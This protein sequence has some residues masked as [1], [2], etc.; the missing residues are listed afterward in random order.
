[1]Q[2]DLACLPVKRAL[3]ALGMQAC[4]VPNALML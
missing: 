1:V 3:F 2:H 4:S